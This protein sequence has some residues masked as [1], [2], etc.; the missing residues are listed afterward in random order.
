MDAGAGFILHVHGF[1]AF[2]VILLSVINYCPWISHYFRHRFRSVC[3]CA[4]A[5]MK[6]SLKHFVSF[7][8][9]CIS[10][11]F[12]GFYPS[13]NVCIVTNFA[14][15]V[16][17]FAKRYFRII[18]AIWRLQSYCL[19]ILS[20]TRL[21]LFLQNVSVFK[22]NTLEKINMVFTFKMSQHLK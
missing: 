19:N 11:V 1:H 12:E 13:K 9:C 2:L 17:L 6:C 14:Q 18:K 4:Q 8:R 21:H 10:V 20:N 16:C 5:D 22:A 3:A 15:N 7:R